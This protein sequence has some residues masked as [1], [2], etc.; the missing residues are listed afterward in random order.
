MQETSGE[1]FDELIP[2]KWEN[3]QLKGIL[4]LPGENGPFV[5]GSDRNED[6]FLNDYDIDKRA[7]SKGRYNYYR[8]YFNPVTCYRK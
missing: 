7:A 5:K 1:G 4:I 8:C 2:Y 3:D 6:Q